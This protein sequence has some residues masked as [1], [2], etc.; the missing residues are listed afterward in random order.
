LANAD[1]K[2]EL[3]LNIFNSVL[4]GYKHVGKS[5][6]HNLV[7]TDGG[8]A[9]LELFEYLFTFPDLISEEEMSD[10]HA[11]QSEL[12]ALIDKVIEERNSSA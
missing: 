12:K 5:F 1:I 11:N 9:N 10:L 4:K 7:G 8:K 3:K 2:P 6:V